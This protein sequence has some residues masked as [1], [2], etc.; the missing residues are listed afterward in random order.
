MVAKVEN[1]TKFEN[2]FANLKILYNFQFLDEESFYRFLD[3]VKEHLIK[4]F[5]KESRVQRIVKRKQLEK[6]VNDSRLKAIEDK[7][8]LFG[9][10]YY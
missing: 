10:G 5:E 9:S 4:L 8:L 1:K 2:S 3:Q 6:K 7:V